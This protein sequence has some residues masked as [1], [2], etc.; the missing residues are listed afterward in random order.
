MS[1]ARTKSWRPA[2]QTALFGRKSA[3]REMSWPSTTIAISQEP[4]GPTRPHRY[5][6]KLAAEPDSCHDRS[7]KTKEVRPNGTP[8]PK[9]S[10]FYG[11]SRCQVIRHG[12]WQIAA[13]PSSSAFSLVH[14]IPVRSTDPFACKLEQAGKTHDRDADADKRIWHAPATLRLGISMGICIWSW[15]LSP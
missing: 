12:L 5:Q 8:P 14:T 3:K 15:P 7:A 1:D 13:A 10:P 6:L 2:H 4:A 9:R 11:P